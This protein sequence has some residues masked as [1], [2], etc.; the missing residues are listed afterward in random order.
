[1]PLRM[2]TK[3][4]V[5][6]GVIAALALSS[7]G[8]G[9][10]AE[11]DDRTVVVA[12]DQP[13]LRQRAAE[14]R[15]DALTL[16]VRSAWYPPSDVSVTTAN[17]DAS[18]AIYVGDVVRDARFVEAAKRYLA[19]RPQLRADIHAART[20]LVS[21]SAARLKSFESASPGQ[22]PKIG[23]EKSV[24]RRSQDIAGLEAFIRHLRAPLPGVELEEL[25]DGAIVR[26]AN[27]QIGAAIAEALG[28]SANLYL[29]T[30]LSAE[31]WRVS[32]NPQAAE[33]LGPGR[34]LLAGASVEM[35][36]REALRDPVDLRTTRLGDGVAAIVVDPERHAAFVEA[37]KKTFA[38]DADFT[39]T[40]APS[41]FLKIRRVGGETDAPG[42][43]A[44]DQALLPLVQAIAGLPLTR[45]MA[46]LTDLAEPP[47]LTSTQGDGIAVHAADPAAN[48]E[49]TAMVQKALAGRSDVAVTRR[50]DQSLAL[51][52]VAPATDP[53]PV[54]EDRLASAVQA[55]LAALKL[56][57]SRLVS[58]ADG[59]LAV[60]FATS[61]DA[62]TFRQGM[63]RSGFAIRLVDDAGPSDAARPPSPRDEQVARMQGSPLWLEPGALI[64]GDMVADAQP[65]F[66]DAG[67]ATILFRLTDEGRDRFAEI[68]AA[69]VGRRFAI[70]LN[71]VIL[72][73]PR[74]EDAI[75]SGQGE[76]HGVFT[77]E[78]A[79]TL[80]RSMLAYRQD[81]PLTLAEPN[82][83]R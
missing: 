49:R 50:P 69:S 57:P 75:V 48:A 37:L 63:M 21:Y 8:A 82:A 17:D 43:K 16:L 72:S 23:L 59:R 55:R 29:V 30:S 56:Q 51:R 22:D 41:E 25:P 36:L 81:L 35:A 68:T 83:P 66:D 52:Y 78:S 58:L 47:M 45:A 1:V 13:A 44:A 74:I 2:L 12:V 77:A 42:G 60:E 19:A 7:T 27:P 53:A 9:R 20:I 46:D 61:N 26:S 79:A 54:S 14:S 62:A 80:A 11:A 39:V 4:L 32:L 15:V 71:G 33:F 10:A 40:E 70:V 38:S 65:G 18:G 6:L 5:G 73:A 31:S 28:A 24:F 34:R 64:T 67:D 76:I 3:A